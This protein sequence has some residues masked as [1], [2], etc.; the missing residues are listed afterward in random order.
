MG[1]SGQ[2][3]APATLPPVKE[4]PVPIWQEAVRAQSQS[5]CC[6]E[7]KNLTLAG[8]QTQPIAH[9]YSNW[10]ILAPLNDI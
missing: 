7:E 5:G 6:G 9:Q 10:A 8:I 3:H 2:L 4:A 1:V